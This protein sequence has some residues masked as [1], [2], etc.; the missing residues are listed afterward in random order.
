MWG[1]LYKAAKK[2]L[3]AKGDVE[4]DAKDVE[5]IHAPALQ[6]LLSLEKGLVEGGR[7]FMLVNATD[8][9]KEACVTLGLE[10]KLAEWSA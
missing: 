3:G 10:D 7:A 2:A 4:V 6:V 8:A 5:R 9:M 1:E